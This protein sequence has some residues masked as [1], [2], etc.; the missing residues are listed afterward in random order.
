M[1]NGIKKGR[2]KLRFALKSAEGSEEG[3]LDKDM[4]EGKRKILQLNQGFSNYVYIDKKQN[5]LFFA[6]VYSTTVIDHQHRKKYHFHQIN[7]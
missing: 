4:R 3:L 5:I 2:R 6:F 1:G 7:R